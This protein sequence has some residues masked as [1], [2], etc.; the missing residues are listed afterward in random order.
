MTVPPRRAALAAVLCLGLLAACG[1]RVDG[2]QVVAESG[3][4]RT[5]RL[6]PESLEA[7]RGLPAAAPTAQTDEATTDSVAATPPRADGA[8]STTITPR[9]PKQSST[10]TS[11]APR[12]AVRSAAGPVDKPAAPASCPAGLAPIVVGHVGLFSG[13]AGPITG[14]SPTT[15]A[16]WANDLNSRG[17]LACHPVKV[18][19]RDDGGDPNKSAAIV[20]DLVK[21][22]GVVA[23]VAPQTILS[24]AGFV[25]A[26]QAAKLPVIGGV[27]VTDAWFSDPLFFPDG[28]SP[29][30]QV[31]GVLKHGAER[32]KTKVGLV[33]CV[34]ASACTKIVTMAKAAAKPAGVTLVYDAPVSI[35]QPDF[36]AQ[37]LNAQKADVDQLVLAVDG[38]SMTRIARSCKAVGFRPLFSTAAGAIGTSQARDETLRSFGVVTANTTAPWTQNDRPG[39]QDYHRA[40]KRWAP[41]VE[42]DGA[43]IATWAS[44]KL[45]EAAV[46]NVAAQARTAPVTSTQLLAGLGKIT[47][48]TLGGL[49]APVTITP[50]QKHATSS[51]CVFYQLLSTDGWTAPRGSR[52]VCL[53]R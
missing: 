33:Y 1:S 12:S 5:V 47:Q 16:A 8:A 53:R 28:A 2:E 40:L 34:E 25:P 29:Q 36:T 30:D 23:F 52:P 41:G 44:A 4:S 19:S 39:L 50:G 48:E 17:G 49:I 18:I 31:I 7:L 26:V 35:T 15:M 11:T 6:T 51:G 13:I 14:N 3:G 27:P 43:S 22:Q 37:C 38:A 9:T 21:R 46:I 45:F 20:N 42:A 24:A 10:P 32:G